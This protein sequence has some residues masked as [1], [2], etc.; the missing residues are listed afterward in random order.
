MPNTLITMQNIAREILP[1][2]RENLVMP[3]TV[4]RD[5]SS[6][7]VG[8][9][10][11]I[12]VEKPA[13]FIADEFGTTINLQT[14]TEPFVSVTMNKIADVSFSVTAR[15]MAL[16]I[17]Q[18][19]TKYLKA[20]A[21][22]IAEKVNQDGLNLYKDVYN[23]VGAS[24]TTPDALEDF[25]NSAKKLNDSKAP[26]M[27]RFAAW[28]TASTAKF[29]VLDAIVN[30]EKSG[31]TEALRTGAI[32]NINGFSN[33]MTQAIKTHTAGGFTSLADV[34]IT[35]GAAAAKSI[36]LTS[37]AGAAITK[38][39][40]GDLFVLDGNQYVVTAQT[41][42][43][44]AGVVTVAIEPALPVAFGDMAAVTVTFPDVTARAHVANLA[45]QRDAFIFV[46][47]PLDTPPGVESYVTM[48]DES[49]LALRVVMDYNI[50]TKVTTMSIDFLYDYVT[51]YPQL[52]T[53]ILG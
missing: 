51:A 46:T 12:Q 40:A 27:D 52:A 32:G 2:L 18:F 4:N 45:Y 1:L 44:V 26:L 13:V 47:R 17:P 23:F 33:Y 5:Y 9:G 48:D 37:T 10:A 34:T 29:Q 50:T 16:S 19:R 38:L 24:A 39:E 11:V 43:A 25:A 8:K 53:R 14:I 3:E 30:A 6:D 15:E 22:A 21:A 35:T 31:S 7:F 20:A 36:V 28:D 49:G 42:A 41:A